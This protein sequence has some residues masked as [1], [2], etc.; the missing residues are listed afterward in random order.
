MIASLE[1]S[2]YMD[3]AYQLGELIIDSDVMREY[4]DSRTELNADPEAQL[5]IRQ[6]V[7]KKE[8]FEEV[9][10]FGKYHPDYD[11]VKKSMREMKRTLDQNE[12]VVRFKKAEKELEKLLNE[13]SQL[14]AFS[15]SE[16]IKVPTGNPFWD[17]GGCGGAG[18]GSGGCSGGCGV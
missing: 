11:A 17:Q 18:C 15:V 8:D 13:I 3:E 9:E 4:T 6:F 1:L 12:L 10:R 16:Q 5:L 2:H 14:I 7:K